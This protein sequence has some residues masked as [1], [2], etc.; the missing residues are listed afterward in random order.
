M[1]AEKSPEELH[2]EKLERDT[3]RVVEMAIRHAEAITRKQ[4]ISLDT[5]FKLIGSFVNSYVL[6]QLKD[7][8]ENIEGTLMEIKEEQERKNRVDE[9]Y[10]EL[11]KT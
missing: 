6:I 3:Q 8:L 4:Q 7:S 2:D 1:V 5:K 10:R 11:D 9:D